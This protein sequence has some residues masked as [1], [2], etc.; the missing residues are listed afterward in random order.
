MFAACCPAGDV[1]RDVDAARTGNLP[2]VFDPD[3]SFEKYVDYA[4]DVP[5]YFV[6][7][8]GQ[9][10]NALGQSWRD[11]MEVSESV[12]DRVCR[13]ACAERFAR[14]EGGVYR[15][16]G[17]GHRL[18]HRQRRIVCRTGCRTGCAVLCAGQYTS[19]VSRSN[20]AVYEPIAGKLPRFC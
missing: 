14:I 11:F 17:A 3:M 15:T 7:R 18:Q 10:V 12:Q 16:I 19:Y 4:M 8:K 5:M 2:F 6:Y 9:Y 1:W 20:M 13:T